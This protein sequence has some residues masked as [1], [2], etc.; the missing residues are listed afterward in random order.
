MAGSQHGSRRT[1][2]ELAAVATAAGRPSRQRTTL[3]GAVTRVARSDLNLSARHDAEVVG[4]GAERA[5]TA[6]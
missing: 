1:P 6:H 2:A 3:Y 5:D 4:A